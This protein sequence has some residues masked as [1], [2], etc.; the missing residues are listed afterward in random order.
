MNPY[1]LSILEKKLKRLHCAGDINDEW[2]T[3]AKEFAGIEALLLGGRKFSI[4]LFTDG[5]ENSKANH[6]FTAKQNALTMDWGHYC[7]LNGLELTGFANPPYSKP[8]L[9][10]DDNGITC[11]G[12][13]TMMKKAHAE[14][15][16]GFFSLWVLPCNPE[17]AFFPEKTASKIIFITGGRLTFAPPKW[18]KQD[19]KG[20]KPMSARGGAIIAIFD[21]DLIGEPQALS[22]LS[23]D[24]LR[25]AG[26]E[27]IKTDKLELTT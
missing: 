25:S 9:G 6:Y 10:L 16:L 12:L 22:F 2:Q 7:K 14:M 20:S 18:Y 8:H 3:P 15:L 24:K 4:D 21:P 17:A 1:A 5:T 11:T 23:R 13:K 27:A 19:P 26:V